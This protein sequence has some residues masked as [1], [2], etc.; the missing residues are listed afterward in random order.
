MF[1]TI[2][3][4][5]T[6][7]LEAIWKMARKY[8]LVSITPEVYLAI[9][10]I[11]ALFYGLGI[12]KR[13][14]TIEKIQLLGPSHF[15]WYATPLNAYTESSTGCSEVRPNSWNPWM[16]S[17]SYVV[18]RSRNRFNHDFFPLPATFLLCRNQLEHAIA[19]LLFPPR[20]QHNW[21]A[22]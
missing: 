13:S 15:R 17:F 9:V 16:M 2:L 11:L 7:P 12:Q 5:L 8:I 1:T 18:P 6:P 19:I 22:H 21:T 10:Y 3:L 14:L 20:S 4:E